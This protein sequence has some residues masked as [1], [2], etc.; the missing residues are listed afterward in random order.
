MTCKVK[1]STGPSSRQAHSSSD[2]ASM[3]DDRAVQTSNAAGADSAAQAP[4][5]RRQ[6]MKPERMEVYSRNAS[7][8]GGVG[9]FVATG[10]AAGIDRDAWGGLRCSSA[11]RSKRTAETLGVGAM[12][13]R[14]QSPE[15]APG[16][17]VPVQ[18]FSCRRRPPAFSPHVRCVSQ[19]AQ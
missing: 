3:N 14:Q 19:S 2:K 6:S 4:W 12:T 9:S 17:A 7:V 18:T 8:R 10:L 16:A 1:C 11:G 15:T 13:R 5:L